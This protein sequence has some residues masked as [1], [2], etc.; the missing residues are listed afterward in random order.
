M[1][2]QQN[3][4]ALRKLL[5]EALPQQVAQNMVAPALRYR[6]GRFANSVQS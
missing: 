3:P 2:T 6:T 4:M 5:N 1:R